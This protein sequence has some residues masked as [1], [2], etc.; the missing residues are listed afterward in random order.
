MKIFDKMIQALEILIARQ[1]SEVI[2]CIPSP[3]LGH[4]YHITWRDDIEKQID[5]YHEFVYAY[6]QILH[7]R[8]FA[9]L[10]K[11]LLVQL[12]ELADELEAE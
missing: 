2:N 9:R 6:E 10:D 8:S 5:V 3:D 1:R 4:S 7:S 11:G 12:I